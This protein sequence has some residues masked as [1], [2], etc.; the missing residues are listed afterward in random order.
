MSSENDESAVYQIEVRGRLGA[1]WSAWFD[2]MTITTVKSADLTTTTTLTGCVTD[3][4]A[5]YGILAR[6]R[7]LGL[8]LLSVQRVEPNQHLLRKGVTAQPSP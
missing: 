1:E 6:V 2:G 4:A 8:S 7:D 3:Q 5:L